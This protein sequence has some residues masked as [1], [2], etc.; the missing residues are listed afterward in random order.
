MCRAVGVEHLI[1]DPRF[2]TNTDRVGNRTELKAELERAFSRYTVDALVDRLNAASVPCGRVRTISEALRD[3]QIA[4]RQMLLEF[5]DPALA[6]FRVLGN[7]IKLSA[8][9]ANPSRRPPRLGEHTAEILK[10][11]S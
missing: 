7:P 6:G 9:P 11:I 10:E 1:D 2:K 4:H 8:S 3:P 5:D